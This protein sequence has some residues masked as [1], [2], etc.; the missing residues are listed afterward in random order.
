MA[1]VPVQRDHPQALARGLSTLEAHKPCSVSHIFQNYH[2][3]GIK[4]VCVCLCIPDS[5]PAHNFIV[6]GWI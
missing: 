6:H 2:R 1:C 4:S 3:K 5:Y